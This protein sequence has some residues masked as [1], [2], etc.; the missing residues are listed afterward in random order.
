[1]EI[2]KGWVWVENDIVLD[3]NVRK[4]MQVAPVNEHQPTGKEGR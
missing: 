2:H 3:N 4:E 1:M